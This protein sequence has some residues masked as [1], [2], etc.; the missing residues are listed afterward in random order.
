MVELHVAS[1]AE[2]DTKNSRVTCEMAHPRF[3]IDS[4]RTHFK[5]CELRSQL[6]DITQFGMVVECGLSIFVLSLSE[7]SCH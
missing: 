6:V 5:E 4:L 3:E 1:R 2:R 7:M